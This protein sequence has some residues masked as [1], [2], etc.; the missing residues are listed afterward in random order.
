MDNSLRHWGIKGMKW[1]IRKDRDAS[2]GGS[3]PSKGKSSTDNDSKKPVSIPQK[4]RK[5]TELS[6]AEL[7]EKINR[8]EMEK[9]YKSLV[10]EEKS[11][12]AATRGKKFVV[13]VL[14]NS[15]RNIA[16][17]TVTYAMGIG[18]NAA[19]KKL[20]NLD[21]DIINPKKGQKDK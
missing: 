1:G 11:S 8:L 18:V 4:K 21:I 6:D 16:T 17:Q 7:R 3:R 10:K 13:D 9:R 5:I 19:A 12:P 20:F 2:G 15:A 14:E